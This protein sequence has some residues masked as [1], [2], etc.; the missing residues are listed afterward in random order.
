MPVVIREVDDT[1]IIEIALI[2]NIQRKDLTPFEEAE[3]LHVAGRAL[4]LHA[5]G[6]GAAA[7]EVADRRSPSRCR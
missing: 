5:R 2:E 7:G 4:R 1:E 3:A 6:H